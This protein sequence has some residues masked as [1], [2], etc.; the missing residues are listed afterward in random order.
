V[1]IT[2]IAINVTTAASGTVYVGIY[3]SDSSYQPN[4][5]L[6]S[7]S[8]SSS[9]TGVK[10]TTTSLTLLPGVYWIALVS[11]AAP[12]LRAVALAASYS[13]ALP[14]LGTANTV[15][16]YTSGSTLPDTAPTSGYTALNG[17]ALPAVGLL[18][19]FV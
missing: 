6:T 9:S 19:S 10:F 5:L 16:W 2:T 4:S 12:T 3:D 7:V 8:F 15:C 14:T 18:Y 11:N 17:S 1:S 13:L